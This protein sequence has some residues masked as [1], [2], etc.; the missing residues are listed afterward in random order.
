MPRKSEGLNKLHMEE[1]QREVMGWRVHW[2]EVKEWRR[3]WTTRSFLKALFLGF[4]FSLFDTGTDLNFAW[5]VPTDCPS[6]NFSDPFNTSSC[7]MIHPRKVE[8]LSYTYIALPGVLFCFSAC[9][10]PL[11]GQLCGCFG[12]KVLQLLGLSAQM[13]LAFGLFLAAAFNDYWDQ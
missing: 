1:L 13:C 7:G 4:V 9:S 8:F 3:H 12:E 10:S 11:K 6:E 2:K 5:S